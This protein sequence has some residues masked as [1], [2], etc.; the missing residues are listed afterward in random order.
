MTAPRPTEQQQSGGQSISIGLRDVYD[1]VQDLAKSYTALSAKIDTALISQTMSQQSIAQTLADMRH[2]LN[3]HEARLRVQEGR[4]FI[5]PKSMWTAIAVL[6]AALSAII[7][8][9]A[10]IVSAAN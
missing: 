9:I 5:T 8:I 10:V 4:A 1:S 7:G 6:I 3:D 2:D